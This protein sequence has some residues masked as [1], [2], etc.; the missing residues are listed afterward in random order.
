MKLTYN[1]R[2]KVQE[3][4]NKIINSNQNKPSYHKSIVKVKKNKDNDKLKERLKNPYLTSIINK[5]TKLNFPEKG[6]FNAGLV[7]YLDKYI[8]VY[9]PDEYSFK[10]CV[11][12][13]DLS[14]DKSSYFK[15]NVTNCSD[16][17]LIWVENKLLM[18][19]SS[20]EE[21]GIKKECI[22]GGIIM[23]LDKSN[24]FIDFKQ[25][26][27]SPENN[28][29]NKNWV[30]FIHNNKIYLIAHISPHIIYEFDLDTKLCEFKYDCNLSLSSTN[31]VKI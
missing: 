1:I 31:I 19:Y 22:R 7:K 12:N 5:T 15:F 24:D 25:F 26:R 30:P 21:V 10:A 3:V 13:K 11:L 29:R 9:R 23:D 14:I 4:R 28:E 18:V 6:S 2:K 20:T 16:P 8:C 27:I 17:R